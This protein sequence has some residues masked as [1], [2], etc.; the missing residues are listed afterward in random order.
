MNKISV[1][2]PTHNRLHTLRKVLPTYLSQDDVKE[3]IIIDDFSRDGTDKYLKIIAKQNAKVRFIKNPINLGQPESQNIGIKFSTGEYLYIG[4][5]DLELSEGFFKTLLSHMIRTKADI[6]A[7]RR[8]WL[9][10][11][12][13]NQEGLLRGNSLS[14]SPFDSRLLITNCEVNVPTDI[15]IPLVDHSMLIAK[16]VFRDVRYDEYFRNTAWREETDFQLSALSQGY[17]IVFCPHAV[18]YH[19]HKLVNKGGNHGHTLFKYELGIFMNN[20]HMVKKHW[21]FL[22]KNFD[23]NY[24]HFLSFMSYRLSRYIFPFLVKIRQAV[25]GVQ[26]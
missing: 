23:I 3:I 11:N 18:S 19:L 25:L 17:K 7:G 15:V 14:E 9:R 10:M 12:E 22:R 24:F 1:I 26:P 20:L 21:K 16:R 5:D 4:E 2:I 8:I 13:T 6:I